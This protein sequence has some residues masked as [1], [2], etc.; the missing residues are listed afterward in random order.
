MERNLY[1]GESSVTNSEC[2]EIES[3]IYNIT[4]SLII[5]KAFCVKNSNTNN[6]LF[7]NSLVDKISEEFEKIA[8]TF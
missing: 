8:N 5:L 6:F 2:M 3:V 1:M 4:D 7:I